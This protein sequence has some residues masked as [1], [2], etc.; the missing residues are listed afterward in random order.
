MP[1]PA[2]DA[3]ISCGRARA[4]ARGPGPEDMSSGPPDL[5]RYSPIS[6]LYFTVIGGPLYV[7]NWWSA[8]ARRTHGTIP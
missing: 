7:G 4:R 3:R 6:M 2:T 1:D 8:T 5:G